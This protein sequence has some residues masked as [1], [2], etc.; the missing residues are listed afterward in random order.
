M[1]RGGWYCLESFIFC[2]VLR[3]G[4]SKRRCLAKPWRRQGAEPSRYME[5][6]QPVQRPGGRKE[7][8]C[9]R[10]ALGLERLEP[11]GR[12]QRQ[13]P[14]GLCLYAGAAAG[15]WAELHQDPTHMLP[16]A[17]APKRMYGVEAGRPM[18][19]L[20]GDA[21]TGQCGLRPG[22]YQWRWGERSSLGIWKA[23]PRRD[24]W[25]MGCGFISVSQPLGEAGVISQQRLR[26]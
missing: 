19:R 23:E 17:A 2:E 10:T 18:R 21:G 26:T 11:G 7:L 13:G 14:V 9:S 12:S 20:P 25:Q 24:S 4:L 1:G 16:R 5:K 15:C 8:L 22:Q 3:A 6:A